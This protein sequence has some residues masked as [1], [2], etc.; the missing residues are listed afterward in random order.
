MSSPYQYTSQ[1]ITWIYENKIFQNDSSQYKQPCAGLTL[2]NIT[3]DDCH[4]FHAN[5]RCTSVFPNLFIQTPPGNDPGI[6]GPYP[7]TRKENTILWIAHMIRFTGTR[8]TIQS[9]TILPKFRDGRNQRI[10]ENKRQFPLQ[11][12][13]TSLW[14]IQNH[15]KF[16][17]R[18]TQAFRTCAHWLIILFEYW[19]I[20]ND[21]VAYLSLVYEQSYYMRIFQR[22]VHKIDHP[23]SQHPQYPSSYRATA[24]TFFH[25]LSAPY[26]FKNSLNEYWV[27][28]ICRCRS[29]VGNTWHAYHLWHARL[30][31]TARQMIWWTRYAL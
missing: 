16:H 19:W 14:R 3:Y 28:T 12:H 31:F 1:V 10:N 8:T 11:N 2:V 23:Y 7:L 22:Q 4:A 5:L 15:S 9:I 24:S 18:C 29:G 21:I 20:R 6:K 17:P 30:F 13:R 25:H 27:Y 26:G